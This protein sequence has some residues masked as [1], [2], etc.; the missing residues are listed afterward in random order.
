MVGGISPIAAAARPFTALAAERAEAPEPNAAPP[1]VDAT[2]PVNGRIPSI[3]VPATIAPPIAANEIGA[4]QSEGNA[5][6]QPD[7]PTPPEPDN[8]NPDPSVPRAA[9]PRGPSGQIEFT[10]EEQAALRQLQQRD[11]AVRAH[12][13]A[14]AAAGAGIA[15]APNYSYVTGP[16]GRQYAVGGEVSISVSANSS[17]PRQA[18]QQLERVVRAALAPAQP[19]GQDRAVAAQASAQIGQLRAQLLTESQAE[20]NQ[21]L[22]QDDGDTAGPPAVTVAPSPLLDSRRREETSANELPRNGV[23]SAYRPGETKTDARQPRPVPRLV[24][25]AI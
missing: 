15:G 8:P 6:A 4:A 18:I 9:R 10:A 11:R 7:T 1:T 3:A 22:R 17:D 23:I 5:P 21:R 19:S 12:E 20:A 14:H 24:N 13:Q 2:G 25:L 16:D